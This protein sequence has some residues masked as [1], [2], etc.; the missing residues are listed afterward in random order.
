MQGSYTHSHDYY[1]Q[2]AASTARFLAGIATT[3]C[4][5]GGLETSQRLI[6]HP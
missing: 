1:P 6:T 3:M 4:E 2:I 5:L